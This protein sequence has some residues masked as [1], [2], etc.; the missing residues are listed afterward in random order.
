MLMFG[1]MSAIRANVMQN[2]G[3]LRFNQ[4]FSA[5]TAIP[6][7]K[8]VVK[9]ERIR[10]VEFL[11]TTG[12][13]GDNEPRFHMDPSTNLRVIPTIRRATVQVANKRE[14]C[15]IAESRETL[16][17]TDCRVQQMRFIFVVREYQRIRAEAH[18]INGTA[19]QM[20]AAT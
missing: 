10:A 9:R 16:V 4:V 17:S 2:T 7:E 13:Q 12:S 20:G 14:Y 5:T 6:R 3:A 19:Q 8:T 11:N 1:S 15:L 18:T